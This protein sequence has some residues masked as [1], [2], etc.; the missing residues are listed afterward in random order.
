MLW[1]GGFGQSEWCGTDHYTQEMFDTNPQLKVDYEQLRAQVAQLAASGTR[2][3]DKIVVPTVVHILWNTCENDISKAQVLD[4]MRVLNEDMARLNPDTNLTRD[5][6]KRYAQGADIEFRLAQVDPSNNPT[7]GINRIQTSAAVAAGNGIKGMTN[8]Q[9]NE[10]FNIWVVESIANFTGGGGTILGYAQFPGSGSWST[11]GIVIRN[12]AFGT[13]GTSGADGRTLTHEV[14]H[15]IDLYHTFQSGCGNNCA[16]SGDQI[17]DTPPSAYSTQS[18]E[19][20]IDLCA[21]D[22]GGDSPYPAG[23]P[24]QIENYMSYNDCQNMFSIGQIDRAIAALSMHS[25]LTNLTSESNVEAKGV[26]GMVA[27]D[28]TTDNLITFEGNSTRFYN[29]T[30]YDAESFEWDFGTAAYPQNST[31]ANPYVVF[32]DVGTH[33][34]KLKANQGSDS[35]EI[36]KEVIVVSKVGNYLPFSENFEDFTELPDQNWVSNDWDEDGLEWKVT[37]EASFAGN[38]SLKMNNYGSCGLTI[39]QLY[40][41]SFD[42][43]PYSSIEMTFKAAFAKRQNNNGDFLRMYVSNDL[44]ETWKLRWVRSSAQLES[45]VPTN[46]NWAPADTSEWKTHTLNLG[47]AYM[48]EGLLVRF[49][50]GGRGGNNFYMDDFE[51]SGVFSG[52]LL[53]EY[54]K[55]GATLISTDPTLNWKSVGG[56]DGYEYQFDT[57]TSFSS[58]NLITGVTS[59]IDEYSGNMDTEADI[60]GLDLETTYYWRARYDTNGVA[61]AWTD[62]WV[63]TTQGDPIGTREAISSGL[64]IFPNPA[65]ESVKIFAPTEIESVVIRDISGR[66]L[67][68]E[69][70]ISSQNYSLSLNGLPTG[71]YLVEVSIDNDTRVVSQLQIL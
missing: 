2:S 9:T 17:C 24:D 21:N 68:E 10:Y 33:T 29:A 32:N 63:F 58:T 45:A 26:V 28:F 14:G 8:W 1:L 60:A 36:E 44:G 7:D 71:L 69:R 35:E 52:D 42:F 22:G 15:C 56:V 4:G 53:L 50:F 37:T 51:V 57:D 16:F 19:Y 65:S 3:N 20:S 31:A 13:I 27:A 23:T 38:Q 11:Y 48:V 46:S 6:F 34:V 40:T 70:G 54:P 67:I 12:D 25:T 62:T 39:D 5:I 47:A 55:N 30:Q 64:K 18:C 49:E 59:Y 61:S 41:S 43:S 66:A